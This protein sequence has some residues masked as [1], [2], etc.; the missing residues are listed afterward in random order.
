MIKNLKLAYRVHL[1]FLIGLGVELK[2]VNYL[3]L[4]LILELVRG[5]L[6]SIQKFSFDLIRTQF[7]NFRILKR[8]DCH[9]PEILYS[10]YSCPLRKTKL[11]A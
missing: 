5:N 3:T 8:F 6:L 11:V 1:V 2:W 4:N 7:E 10:N 9:F